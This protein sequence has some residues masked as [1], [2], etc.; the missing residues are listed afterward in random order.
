MAALEEYSKSIGRTTLILDT[1]TG[2]GAEAFYEKI[3]WIKVGV[4]PEIAWSTDK[5]KCVP[6]TYFYKLLK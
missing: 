5:S 2:S 3:G 6:V 1:E 4:I